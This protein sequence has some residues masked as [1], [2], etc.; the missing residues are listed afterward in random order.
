VCRG[1]KKRLEEALEGDGMNILLP[2]LFQTVRQDLVDESNE[3]KCIHETING[4]F[5][6]KHGMH[7]FGLYC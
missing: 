4:W 7:G 1:W 5:S 3:M 2:T 6:E